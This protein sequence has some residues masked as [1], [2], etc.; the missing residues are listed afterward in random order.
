MVDVILKHDVY[1]IIE[2]CFW[3][4]DQFCFAMGELQ[5]VDKM[6]GGTSSVKG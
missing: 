5:Y 2:L 1:R 6:T 3:K 4:K